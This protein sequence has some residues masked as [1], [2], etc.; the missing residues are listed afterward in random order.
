MH[1]ASRFTLLPYLTTLAIL[2]LPDLSS[3]KVKWKDPDPALLAE[4]Q[5]IID[6]GA[7]AETVNWEIRVTDNYDGKGLR[8]EVVHYRRVKIFNDRG[9]DL[10]A[11]VE[12]PYAKGER[13]YDVSGRTIRPNGTVVELQSTAVF[14]RTTVKAGGLKGKAKSFA[15]PGVEP[16]AIIEY[17]WTSVRREDLAMN[18]IL[19]AQRSSPVRSLVM[20]FTPL[21]LPEWPY[22]MRI[23]SFNASY[24]EPEKSGATMTIRLSK[25]RGLLDEPYMPPEDQVRAWFLVDYAS[26]NEPSLET[27][28][29]DAGKNTYK[30]YGGRSVAAAVKNKADSLTAG[31]TDPSERLRALHDFCRTQIRNVYNDA[32]EYTDDFRSKL[33]EDTK[34]TSEETLRRGYGTGEDINLLLAALAEAAGFKSRAA[35]VA[36]RSEIF[37]R[38]DNRLAFQLSEMIIAVEVAGQ[39]KFFD[40]ASPY[41]PAGMLPWW[42][43]S[44]D[45]LILDAKEPVFV[46]T[47]LSLPSRSLARRAGVLRLKEDGTLEGEIRET[48]TG[49]LAY[50]RKEDLDEL[51]MIAR[52]DQAHQELR[53]RW[54][55]STVESLRVTGVDDPLQ[56]YEMTYRISIP[57]YAE[58]AGKRL[59]LQPDLFKRGATPIFTSSTRTHWL[60]FRYP[61]AEE[62]SVTIELPDGYEVEADAVPPPMSVGKTITHRMAAEVDGRSVR[63]HRYFAFGMDG[64]ILIDPADYGRVKKSMETIQQR[65]AYA[66]TLRPIVAAER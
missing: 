17:Q 61:W 24:P 2:L 52:L 60:Y 32:F 16:G 27:F 40:P 58:R 10:E 15:M 9:R 48:Y 3:A 4:T 57:G 51:S 6:P 20:V 1:R 8:S 30:L 64:T 34:R 62:D 14:D 12:I 22:R 38:R 59:L 29:K 23:R 54:A 36:D 66:V 45:A 33:L 65:D 55:A 11:T 5:G 44:Q 47:P 19:Y 21:E 46:S 28:W 50:R 43:E 31:L 56:S 39:W 41:L 25:I 35:F 18:L 63:L 53:E 49:H 37:F 42:E 26:N 13:V 7:P